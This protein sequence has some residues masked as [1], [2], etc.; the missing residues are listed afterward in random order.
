M[1]LCKPEVRPGAKEESA[2]P[3]VLAA[4]AMN[5]RD[6]PKVYILGLEAIEI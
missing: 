1:N 4:T 2:S 3:V 6:T 5:A